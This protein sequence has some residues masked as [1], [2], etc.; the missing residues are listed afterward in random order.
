MLN[1]K[2]SIKEKPPENKFWK[3]IRKNGFSTLMG[4]GIVIMIVSPDAKS[5][6]LRQMML[7][8]LLMPA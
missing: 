3:F 6:M 5:F 8:G 4:I 7:T 1:H 2:E